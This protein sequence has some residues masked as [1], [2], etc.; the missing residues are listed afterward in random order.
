MS[1]RLF[2]QP[3]DFSAS[4]FY[5]T[6]LEEYQAQFDARLPVEEYEIQLIDGSDADVEVFGMMGVNQASIEKF[7]EAA[8]EYSYLT[9]DE[10]TAVK[11]IVEY[12]NYSFQY[13]M[14][15]YEDVRIYRG[16]L[17]DVGAEMV[18]E[19]GLLSDIPESVARYFDFES[20]ARDIEFNGGLIE[21]QNEVYATPSA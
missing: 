21:F 1:I 15:N 2:A 8:E 6:S 12:E 10:M 5:F 7:F 16:T 14:D 17:A 20:Y 18:E 11:F 13:A 9:E 19:S 4:G 3:Y